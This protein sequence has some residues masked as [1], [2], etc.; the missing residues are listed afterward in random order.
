ML[1]SF[2]NEQ[3]S[4]AAATRYQ[5]NLSTQLNNVFSDKISYNTDTVFS[6]FC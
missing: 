2:S 3:T 4:P 5:K 1:S 6:N